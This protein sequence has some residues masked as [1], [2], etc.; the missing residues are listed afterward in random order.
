MRIPVGVLLLLLVT[1][2]AAA[3]E[4]LVIDLGSLEAQDWRLDDLHLELELQPRAHTALTVRAA[5]LS[6]G[7]QRIEHLRL[8]CDTFELLSTQVSCAQGRLDASSDSFDAQSAPAS[9]QYH[10]DTGELSLRVTDVALAAG[11][12]TIDLH[13]ADGDWRVDARLNEIA[14]GELYGLLVTAGTELPDLQYQGR[15]SGSVQA[16]GSSDGLRE[17]IWKLDMHDTGYSN[18]VG[19]QAAEALRLSTAG[20][21]TSTGEAWQIEASLRA[22]EGMLYTDPLY[23]EFNDSQNLALDARLQWRGAAREL[24]VQTLNFDHS[25]VAEGTARGLLQFNAEPLLDEVELQIN[26]AWLPGLY[27]N[28]LQPWLSATVLADLDTAGHLRGQVSVSAGKP[29]ALALQL[30]DLSLRDSGGLFGIAGLDAAL[31]W[32]RN[33]PQRVSTLAWEGANFYQLQL[34]AAGVVLESGPQSL[35]LRDPMRV[36]LLD[37]RLHVEEFELEI[38]AEGDMRWLLDGNLTPV[39]M[40]AFSRALDWPPLSGKLSGMVPKVRYESHELTIGGALLVQAFDGDI[41]VRN[42]RIREPLGLA[43][44]LWADATIKQLDLE[45]LTS[46]FEFGRIEGRLNGGVENL[47]MEAWQP[48]AFD[49]Q[50]GTPPD[51]RS[52]HRISQKAV[53]NIANLGGAGVAGVLS[54]S[55]L[56]FFEEFPYRQLGIKCELRNGVCD[57]GGIAPADNGY[58]LVEGTLLPPR[59][60]VIGYADRVDWDSLVERLIAATRSAPSI[61]P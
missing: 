39:S 28:W 43:P 25:Q 1:T 31:H 59:L 19:S 60:D 14:I 11:Q 9:F 23:L 36:P 55:M 17:L 58:Y 13:S 10:F 26:D 12:V 41:V 47:Y 54:R 4:R 16:Q 46:T 35:K 38:D 27:V 22:R 2:G 48:V 37:G 50:F 45:T 40:Q 56:R 52:R 42:L 8:R 57:M 30:Q 6:F 32:D 33:I 21:A 49:A 61:N 53:D 24:R 3:A 29:H 5:A 15:I 51:D 34:G 44:R 18:A 20:N 7:E